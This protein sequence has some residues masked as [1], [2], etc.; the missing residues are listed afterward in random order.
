MSQ[1]KCQICKN[2]FDDSDTYEYRGFTFCEEH[3]HEGIE[4]VDYKRREVMEVVDGSTKSQRVGE[5]RNN[6]HKYD[7]HTV[8]SDGLPIGKV[9]EPQILKDYEDGIL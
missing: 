4:K 7:I 1:N 2:F 3:F 8:A 9:K 6:S 5:F